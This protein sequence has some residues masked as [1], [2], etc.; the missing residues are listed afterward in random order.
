MTSFYTD[1]TESYF[2]EDPTAT[3]VYDVVPGLPKPL[4]YRYRYSEGFMDSVLDIVCITL[5]VFYSTFLIM[6]WG[7][8]LKLFLFYS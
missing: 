8:L 6:S 2:F 3:T 5:T 7:F 4:S 1:N